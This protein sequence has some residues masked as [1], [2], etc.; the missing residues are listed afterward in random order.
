MVSD[1][2][3]GTACL[4]LAKDFFRG[5]KGYY[6]TLNLLAWI[7]YHQADI[8]PR[9]CKGWHGDLFQHHVPLR[10]PPGQHHFGRRRPGGILDDMGGDT[11]HLGFFVD[12]GTAAGNI[13]PP[14]IA[15][16]VRF[17]DKEKLRATNSGTS[18]RSE[19]R[20]VELTR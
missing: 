5:I 20:A 13:G 1:D 3:V 6:D 17:Q 12:G 2:A 18:S 14:L 10:F 4:C 8:I 19:D 16:Q 11:N 7:T 9:L 15:M